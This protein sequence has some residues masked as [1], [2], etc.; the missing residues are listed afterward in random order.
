[1][2]RQHYRSFYVLSR[3]AVRFKSKNNGDK[4]HRS[5]YRHRHHDSSRK[6]RDPIL[7][8][9]ALAAPCSPLV[10]HPVP[11]WAVPRGPVEQ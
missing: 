8:A 3:Q 7:P 2:I 11:V 9:N 6:T 1:M 10:A 5:M 4:V